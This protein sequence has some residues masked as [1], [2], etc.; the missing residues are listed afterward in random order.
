MKTCERYGMM[1][2]H[3]LRGMSASS[4]HKQRVHKTVG[5]VSLAGI[6]VS[7]YFSVLPLTSSLPFD[8]DRHLLLLAAIISDGMDGSQ[9]QIA[10]L[11]CYRL[12]TT[13]SGYSSS[14]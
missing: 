9:S 3:E 5:S 4:V 11:N 10:R 7:E 6:Y 12:E 14:D 13:S 8:Q 2:I 1:R